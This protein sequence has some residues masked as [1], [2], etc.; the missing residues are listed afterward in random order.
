MA[1]SIANTSVVSCDGRDDIFPSILS[2]LK[3]SLFEIGENAVVPVEIVTGFIRFFAF[4]AGTLPSPAVP[5][6]ISV[7]LIDFAMPLLV[8]FP[9]FDSCLVLSLFGPLFFFLPISSVGLSVAGL[10]NTD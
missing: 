9:C 1:D 10:D 6:P 4:G 5:K 8:T 2:D 3:A 7:V